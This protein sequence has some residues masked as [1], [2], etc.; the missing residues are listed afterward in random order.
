MYGCLEV[1]T[2]TDLENELVRGAGVEE[3]YRVFRN[4]N[5]VV[6]KRE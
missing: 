3:D 4:M 2:E 1:W 5:K 6:K